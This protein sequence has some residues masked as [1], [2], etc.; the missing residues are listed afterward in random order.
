MDM[1]ERVREEGSIRGTCIHFEPHNRRLKV[2]HISQLHVQKTIN[3]LKKIGKEQ[4]CDKLIFY[5]NEANKRFFVQSNCYYEGRIG[6]F[7]SG[8]DAYIFSIFLE[9]SRRR[10]ENHEEDNK[11]MNRVNQ[12]Y[13]DGPNMNVQSYFL[14]QGYS[15]R[16]PEEKDAI[17][18]AEL[19]GSVF[20]TYPTPIHEPEFVLEMIKNDH[21]NLTVVEYE[22]RIISACSTEIL[23]DF[24]SAEMADCATLPEHRGNGLLT[25]QFCHL[26]QIMHQKKIKTLF[27][28]SRSRSLG[29][30]LVNRKLGFTYGGRMIKNSNISGR[31]EN[32]NI[33]Y[34]N[35]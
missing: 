9:P 33:W 21:I 12:K 35:I 15:M 27:T 19:Y 20:E 34:K 5:A 13:A 23:P 31:L 26:I 32:M 22:Q 18:I 16:A 10:E 7:F 17:Y 14:P 11:V 24:N 1:I 25:S 30:N 28:Y 8:D 3:D 29:M 4:K 6:G 2:Y